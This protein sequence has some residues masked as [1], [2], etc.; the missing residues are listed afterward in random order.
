MTEAPPAAPDAGADDP[1]SGRIA[2]YRD[3]RE[4]IERST[5]SLATSVDGSSFEVQASLHHLTLTRGCY[6]VLETEAGVRLGQVTDVSMHSER[7][8][9]PGASG[10]SSGVVVRLAVG[11]GLMLD[12][13]AM[14]FHDASVRV[15]RP[16]E[17]SGWFA[18]SGPDRALLTIGELAAAPGV[19][20]SLDSG[21]FNRHTFMC[22]QSGSGKTYS[23][24]LLLERVLAETTLRVVILDPNSDYRGLSRLREDADPDV[25]ARYRAVLDQVAVWSG[26]PDAELPLRLRFA[27][28]GTSAQ[29]AVLGIDP[30]ADREEFAALADLLRAAEHGGPLITEPDQL[31]KAES[32]G[33]RRLGMRAANL[34]VFDWSVWAGEQPSILQELRNPT[35]RC[36]VVDLGSLET[37]HEQRVVA[38]AVLSTLWELR[39]SRQPCLVVIDEAHNVC[40]AEP[41][42]PL[43]GLSTATTVQ[44]AAEGRKFGLY[45]L[46]STQRPNKVHQNVVSQCDNLLLMRMNSQAD[47]ADL[48]SFFSFVPPGLVAGASSFRMGQALVGGKFFP[49]AGYV[50]MG[51]R[52]TQEGGADVPTTWAR[53]RVERG[54]SSPGLDKLPGSTPG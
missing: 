43:T 29:G 47:L 37:V 27:E 42:D 2:H 38:E 39:R 31:L 32:E 45:L 19:P 36:V 4:Q 16:E 8:D 46:V 14:P 30:I 34:G 44:I 33:P 17:V 54:L 22:G 21:G 5:L 52:V 41:E 35:S 3:V 15:A 18:E 11:T 20:A 53:P 7:V 40:A 10:S 13:D 50:V 1:L 26:D 49:Q 48:T 25:A 28:L 51:A 23:L 24:G 9:V 6:V 12:A